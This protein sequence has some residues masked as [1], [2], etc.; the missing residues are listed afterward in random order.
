MRRAAR[1]LVA[2]V[3]TV[4]SSAVSAYVASS[5]FLDALKSHASRLAYGASTLPPVAHSQFCLRYPADCEIRRAFTHRDIVLTPARWNDLVQVN[6]AV[7]RAII[8]QRN[9]GGV[10]TEEWPLAPK[11]GDCNDYAVTKRHQLL[12]R[13]WPSRVLILSEV[14]TDSGEHHLIL[15]VRMREGDFVLDSLSPNI[16]PA[17]LVRYRWVRA[18]LPSNPRFWSRVSAP[19]S[20]GTPLSDIREIRP[21]V[22]FRGILQFY[23][24][25]GNDCR[26]TS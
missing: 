20:R 3:M 4:N 24:G 2:T 26:A 12:A 18:Q 19:V 11:A 9:P 8:P 23:R 15:V 7:N 17:A 21:R 10:V 5:S 6:S 13:G 14:V 16:L 22:T 1:V 25:I